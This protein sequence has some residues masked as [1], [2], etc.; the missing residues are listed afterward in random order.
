MA[1]SDSG[2]ITTGSV[3]A[4]FHEAL[5]NASRNQAVDLRD[6]I[7]AYLV[8][9]LESYSRT[10]ALLAVSDEGKHHKPLAMIY[11][12][13]QDARSPEQRH[14]ALRE[15]G[16]LA[17]FIAGIFTDSLNRKLV[18]VDYYIG[19]GEAAYSSLH[20][21]LRQY[22]DRF[23]RCELF[24]ELG[25]EFATLVDVLTE[26]SEMSGLKSNSDL[27]RTYEIWQRTG[28]ERAQRQLIR[29]GIHPLRRDAPVAL[30]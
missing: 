29:S 6:S 21:S 1:T 16:D 3:R 8:N 5:D 11:A 7:A 30:H 22:G 24:E 20:D 9:L 19:M 18:D 2:L 14:H 26:I 28:S 25:R 15:L 23:S 17:L 10:T 27:L 4:Y 12:D 13:A